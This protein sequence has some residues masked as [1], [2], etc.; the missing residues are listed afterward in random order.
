MP[1]KYKRFAIVTGATSGIGEATA[2]KFIVT[3]PPHVHISDIVV[4]PTRQGYP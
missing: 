2:R 3:Q 1:D 4:R